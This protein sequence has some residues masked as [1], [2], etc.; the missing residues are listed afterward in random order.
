MFLFFLRHTS[1]TYQQV[2]LI[3]RSLSSVFSSAPLHLL[4][5]LPQ[6]LLSFTF[7]SHLCTSMAEA[8][9]S[10]HSR[11]CSHSRQS[12]QH[13]PP[14]AEFS[15]WKIFTH[16]LKDM[17]NL[18]DE[19]A[20]LI[21]LHLE[22][23]LNL[24]MNDSQLPG[25]YL[26]SSSRKQS[27]PSFYLCSEY[28]S[29]KMILL[30]ICLFFLC[31]DT[32][33]TDFSAF[34][35]QLSNTLVSLCY[36]LCILIFSYTCVAEGNSSIP[37]LRYSDSL[38]TQQCHQHTSKTVSSTAFCIIS[39]MR[40][41]SE[42]YFILASICPA[43]MQEISLHQNNLTHLGFLSTLCNKVLSDEFLSFAHLQPLHC[44]YIDLFSLRFTCQQLF[45]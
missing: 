14:S 40:N 19:C 42:S 9:I 17:L 11:L 5:I 4:Q 21:S 8:S 24:K 18:S 26:N 15:L 29:M 1:C 7:S 38:P 13:T 2:P 41:I 44:I 28:I 27:I 6:S 45:Q 16:L 12:L 3:K 22:C 34:L 39:I 20:L 23:T 30:S 35:P 37:P 25:M 43:Y 10:L 32:L 33:C 36:C 31:E